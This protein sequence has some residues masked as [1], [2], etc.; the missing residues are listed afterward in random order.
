[1]GMRKHIEPEAKW[2]P[3][4][5]IAKIRFENDLCFAATANFEAAVKTPRT[6]PQNI[7]NKRKIRA[8]RD[9]EERCRE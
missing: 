4:F 1:M 5:C 9:V 3:A 7:K 2:K 8:A 6:K